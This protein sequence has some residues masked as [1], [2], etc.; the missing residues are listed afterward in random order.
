MKMNNIMDDLEKRGGNLRMQDTAM[1]RLAGR[2]G[3]EFSFPTNL[4]YL[5]M[6]RIYEERAKEAKRVRW[7][8]G[9]V[10]VLT[11]CLSALALFVF[12]GDAFSKLYNNFMSYSINTS[13][14]SWGILTYV[15]LG[16]CFIFFVSLNTMLSR[17]FGK[18]E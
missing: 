15:G 2:Q 4:P 10:I 11:I 12:C 7:I 13:S 18:K 3:K 8:D 5:T 17:Y 9:I 1:K 6:Q 14:F 16:I